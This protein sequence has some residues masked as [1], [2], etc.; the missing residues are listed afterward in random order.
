MHNFLFYLHIC[1]A[2]SRLGPI[3]GCCNITEAKSRE[4]CTVLLDKGLEVGTPQ[5]LLKVVKVTVYSL[6][7]VPR[8]KRRYSM[9]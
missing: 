6:G 3:I 8:S 1:G 9:I 4:V 7:R 5:R 2:R